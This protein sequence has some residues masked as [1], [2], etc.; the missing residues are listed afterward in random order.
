MSEWDIYR[1]GGVSPV[2]NDG[3]SKYL[4]KKIQVGDSWLPF[5]A[6]KTASTLA[7]LPDLPANLANLGESGIRWG[8]SKVANILPLEQTEQLE[9]FSNQPNYFRPENVDRPSKWINKGLNDIGIDITP[10]PRDGL[11]RIAAHGIEW[12][13]PGGLWGKFSKAGNTAKAIKL[14]AGQGALGTASGSA[15]ELLGV[16]P[17]TADLAT[18]GTQVIAPNPFSLLNRFSKHGKLVAQEEAVSRLLKDLTKEQDLDRLK[19]FTSESLDVIPVT[20]EVALNKNISNL[21][22]AY[23]PNL[24]GIQSKQIAND[25]VLRRKLNALGAELSPSSIEVGEAGR[26]LIQK[27]LDLL[28]KVRRDAAAS[29]YTKLEESSNVYPVSNFNNYTDQAII[30]ELGDIEKGL[31][32][33]KNI[34]P[35]KYKKLA[36]KSK[37]E[38][39]QLEKELNKEAV[40][41]DK[42][43]SNLSPQAKEQIL[44]QLAPEFYIKTEK[45]NAL[46]TEITKLESGQYRPG[47]IDKAITEIGNNITE[48]KRS[49]KGGNNSLI[50]HFQHQKKALEADLK[51]TPEGLAHR[52]VYYQ[53]SPDIN[54]INRDKLLKKFV[55]KDEWGNYRVPAEDLPRNLMRSPRESINNYMTHV[56]GTDAENL[57]KAYIRDMYLGKA[58]DHN[59]PTYD[60]SSQFLRQRQDKLASIYSPEELDTFNNINNYLKNRAEVAKGNSVFGSATTPKKQ[61]QE[62]VVKYLG[63][64]VTKPLHFAKYVPSLPLKYDIANFTKLNPKYAIL[65]QALIDPVYAKDLV[66]R[67]PLVRSNINRYAPS[68]LTILNQ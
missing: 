13:A 51:A 44:N 33:H 25:E 28:E 48:L 2:N 20:A 9:E 21:H 42:Q 53:H 23:A 56:K 32:Q 7:E 66:T 39:L 62:N 63:Q 18:M 34:L 31:L 59:L 58:I 30:K 19:N 17:L 14:T 22:N 68:L 10:N 36:A 35:E 47:Y 26:E 65:E 40:Q 46:K 54:S 3:W 41:L 50:R 60:K 43:Y 6:K 12:G 1:V 15:Q 29:L 45:I 55:N 4:V 11:Q 16:D 5:I 67:S 61:L 38:L 27:K 49:R 52:K 24:T 57:T 64:E 37:A 8:A